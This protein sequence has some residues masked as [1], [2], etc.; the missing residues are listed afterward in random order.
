MVQYRYLCPH[1]AIGWHDLPFCPF[2]QSEQPRPITPG[3]MATLRHL[4]QL[5][6]QGVLPPLDQPLLNWRW[7]FYGLLGFLVFFVLLIIF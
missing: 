1:C 7:V 3:E 6:R 2:R 5:E 4:R